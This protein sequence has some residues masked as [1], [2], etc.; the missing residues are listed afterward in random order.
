[1][2]G[3]KKKKRKRYYVPVKLY[4]RIMK[5]D[6]RRYF[7]KMMVNS[8][9]SCT[10]EMM[11][12]FLRTYALPDCHMIRFA[13]HAVVANVPKLQYVEG[14]SNIVSIFWKQMKVFPDIAVRLIDCMIA[15]NIVDREEGSKVIFDIESRFTKVF[16]PM[17][18]LESKDMLESHKNRVHFCGSIPSNTAQEKTGNHWIVPSTFPAA[19]ETATIAGNMSSATS[20]PTTGMETIVD[21]INNQKLAME[22]CTLCTRSVQYARIPKPIAFTRSSRITVYLDQYNRL[23]RMEVNA[24]SAPTVIQEP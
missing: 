17:C 24:A 4:P 19:D 10:D 5:S 8:F 20:L 11:E 14:A 23:Y 13:P 12:G 1:L 22:S 2:L 21:Q 3:L 6:I 16:S 9:N 15:P 18:A 7:S